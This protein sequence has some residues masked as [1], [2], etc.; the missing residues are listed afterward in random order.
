MVRESV[1]WNV[2]QPGMDASVHTGLR[3][4]TMTT[5]YT[6]GCHC[7]RVRY[8][9]SGPD[10]L[11]VS[12]CNCSICSKSGYLAMIVP[13]AQFEL[14]QG[15]E[16]LVE[17]KF[18]TGTARHLFCLHCGIKSFYVP[19]SHPDGI[20]VNA[21]CLDSILVKDMAIRKFDGRRWERQY[22]TGRAESS[23]D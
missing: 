23:P 11:T 7:G 8:R 2:A 12:Q 4:Y 10:T 20:S 14:I 19:R 9:V 22:P 16:H 15:E 6:G 1:E 21:R 13:K 5:T 3:I 17:Y 18:N